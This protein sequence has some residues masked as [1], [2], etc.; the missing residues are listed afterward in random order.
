MFLKELNKKERIAFINL[1]HALSNVDEVFS[2]H[3][4]ELIDEYLEELSLDNESIEKLTLESAAK[5]LIDSSDRAKNIIYFE[6]F[7]VALIDGEF[8]KK[9]I[10]FLNT[11]ASKLNISLKKQQDF[12][13]YFKTVKEAYDGTFVNYESKLDELEKLARELI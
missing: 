10:E 7:G 1:V 11:L 9:E 2:N 12:I 4:K 5:E 13:N 8:D 6:L 3:E